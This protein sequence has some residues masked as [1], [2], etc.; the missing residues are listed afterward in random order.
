MT[1]VTMRATDKTA[2]VRKKR[3]TKKSTQKV[4][5]E[6]LCNAMVARVRK[7]ERERARAVE[8]ATR[9]GRDLSGDPRFTTPSPTS[10]M[11]FGDAPEGPFPH[12]PH[13][14]R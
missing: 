1:S 14:R 7:R 6:R 9:I 3:K 2:V 13:G 11:D 5:A 12:G 8:E 4:L 10:E